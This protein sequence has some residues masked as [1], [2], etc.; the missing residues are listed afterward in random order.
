M[1][2][3]QG[4]LAPNYNNSYNNNFFSIQILQFKAFQGICVLQR[5]LPVCQYYQHLRRDKI[6][7]RQSI[8]MLKNPALFATPSGNLALTFKAPKN[9]KRGEEVDRSSSAS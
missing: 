7:R 8:D 3:L 4:P 1:P 2:M 6:W 9:K 5:A